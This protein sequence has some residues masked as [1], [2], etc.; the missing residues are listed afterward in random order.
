MDP[1]SVLPRRCSH[2]MPT[3]APPQPRGAETSIRSTITAQLLNDL[4]THLLHLLVARQF[5][6]P[7]IFR[8]FSSEMDSTAHFFGDVHGLPGFLKT[9]D[10]CFV[11]S[12][13]FTYN[14]LNSCATAMAVA[15]DDDKQRATVWATLQIGN[16]PSNEEANV[17]RESVVKL[18]WEL[19]R[20]EVWRCVRL[21]MMRGGPAFEGVC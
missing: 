14:L 11:L 8:Y 3:A 4:S 16:P 17:V 15:G 1:T 2:P 21:S 6:H 10:V 12:S 9:C 20:E 7:S 13:K 19:G 5:T 18:D